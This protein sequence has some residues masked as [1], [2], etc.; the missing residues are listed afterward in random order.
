M[1]WKIASVTIEPIKLEQIENVLQ[2]VTAVREEVFPMLPVGQVPVDMQKLEQTYIDS[3]AAIFLVA[4]A[5]D[6]SILG[7]VGVV[8]YDDRIQQVKGRYRLERTA[9]I[10][11]CYVHAAARRTG[12]GSMLVREAL[13]FSEQHGYE[14]LYLHTQRFLPGAVGFWER[15]GFTIVCEETDDWQTVHMERGYL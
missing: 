4:A 14:Q 15:H 9:E 10:V 2:F 11:R 13:R 3:E 5:E 12:I 7:T 1:N 8:T 6:G